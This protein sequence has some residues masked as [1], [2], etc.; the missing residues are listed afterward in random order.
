MKLLDE[1]RAAM[2]G[3]QDV[4]HQVHGGQRGVFVWLGSVNLQVRVS[5][6]G[7][8]GSARRSQSTLEVDPGVDALLEARV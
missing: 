1:V 7:C 2:L 3:V 4:S 5:V 8:H 6:L